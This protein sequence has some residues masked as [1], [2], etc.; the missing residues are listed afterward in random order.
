MSKK[1]SKK[2]KVDFKPDTEFLTKIKKKVSDIIKSSDTIRPTSYMDLL[3]ST[4]SPKDGMVIV[5]ASGK[6]SFAIPLGATPEQKEIFRILMDALRKSTDT[7]LTT[8]E[9]NIDFEE[10]DNFVD[11]SKKKTEK[12]Q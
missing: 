5:G 4:G 1:K 2:N 9:S 6:I 8:D 7:S 3:G 10:F 11:A 12:P